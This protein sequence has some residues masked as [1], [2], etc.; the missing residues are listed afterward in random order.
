MFS[1]DDIGASAVVVEY[2]SAEKAD[3]ESIQNIGIIWKVDN[4]QQ[5]QQLVDMD[6]HAGGVYMLSDNMLP[7]SIED[8]ALELKD[9]LS[10]YP[11]R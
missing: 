10:S 3:M 2:T 8:D 5:I 11:N 1:D 4:V 9:I 6:S 7:S